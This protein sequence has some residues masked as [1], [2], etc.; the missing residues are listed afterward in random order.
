MG[1]RRIQ[2][3]CWKTCEAQTCEV[4]LVRMCNIFENQFP[5]TWWTHLLPLSYK[6]PY[7]ILFRMSL[8]SIGPG[9]VNS[10]LTKP[11]ELP[12]T[13]GSDQICGSPGTYSICYSSLSSP[14]VISPP[15][16]TFQL[17]FSPR[18]YSLLSSFPRPIN[19]MNVGIFG[20]KC[21]ILMFYFF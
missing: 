15:P 11:F 4:L 21:H 5:F 9:A 12:S 7:S 1:T 6:F 8:S 17:L 10:T 20:I 18:L 16:P 13:L 19:L 3:I 2:D 14:P